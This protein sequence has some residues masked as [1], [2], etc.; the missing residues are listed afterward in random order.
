MSDQLD[1]LARNVHEWP[2]G[3][4]FVCYSRDHGYAI[5]HEHDKNCAEW[6]TRQ[7]WLDRRA[8]LQG[9]PSWEDAPEWAQWLCQRDSGSWL[10]CSGKPT[11][12]DNEWYGEFAQATPA[13][14][15]LGDWRDTLERRPEDSLT[16]EFVA[17]LQSGFEP[18]TSLE[19]SQPVTLHTIHH[20]AFLHHN[21]HLL[22]NEPELVVFRT[23]DGELLHCKPK[24]CLIDPDTYGLAARLL[25]DMSGYNVAPEH[26]RELAEQM[27]WTV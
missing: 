13:E 4:N 14:E 20:A 23:A 16:E 25:S 11:L 5:F 1:W 9:K 26:M 22:L 24:E 3:K 15:V 6:F 2:E 18:L 7:Q 10:W 27:G 19:D 8:E 21:C 17:K 12:A